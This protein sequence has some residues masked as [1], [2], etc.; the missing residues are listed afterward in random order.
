MLGPLSTHPHEDVL[1]R[2]PW[3]VLFALLCH[4]QVADIL[5][6][7]CVGPKLIQLAPMKI[8]TWLVLPTFPL[9]V[10]R[11]LRELTKAR[12]LWVER[13]RM[14]TR[15]EIMIPTHIFCDLDDPRMDSAELE[16]I[17]TAHIR[18]PSALLEASV[19]PAPSRVLEN[20]FANPNVFAKLLPG[21]RF[22]VT[23]AFENPG[24]SLA[25]ILSLWDMNAEKILVD[26]ASFEKPLLQ[27]THISTYDSSAIRLAVISG[28][29]FATL[30]VYLTCCRQITNSRVVGYDIDVIEMRW[31]TERS[32]LTT[33]HRVATLAGLPVSPRRLAIE[34]ELICFH[35]RTTL[36]F[37]NWKTNAL[38]SG[39]GPDDVRL[40]FPSSRLRYFADFN[41][42]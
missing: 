14:L 8:L 40:E 33:M 3:D 24:E 29:R 39:V 6:L 20:I 34:D 9:Q 7:R 31:P 11:V 18:A 13:L 19:L 15:E 27:C 41:L 21:G 35:T 36:I 5:S 38:M 42:W 1:T 22:I 28:T 30:L 16:R 37:W 10:C 26:S 32:G 23:G 25:S 2:N 17:V 4:V 12:A